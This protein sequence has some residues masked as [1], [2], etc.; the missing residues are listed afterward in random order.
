MALCEHRSITGHWASQWD[1]LVPRFLSQPPGDVYTGEP[2]ILRMVEGKLLIYA[3]GVDGDDDG[4]EP[5]A[6]G[7]DPFVPGWDRLEPEERAS[8]DWVLFPP[9][10]EP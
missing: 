1:E 5:M 4:G 3:R 6:P 9:R 10:F 8:G 7:N 2:L